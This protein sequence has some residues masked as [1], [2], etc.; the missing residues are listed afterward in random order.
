MRDAEPTPPPRLADPRRRNA[1]GD[2]RVPE[3][4]SSRQPSSASHLLPASAAPPSHPTTVPAEVATGSPTWTMA[5]TTVATMVA[6][7]AA[8]AATADAVQAARYCLGCPGG[9]RHGRR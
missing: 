5:A 7:M 1:R 9:C 2:G 6:T 4:H 3:P 8:G